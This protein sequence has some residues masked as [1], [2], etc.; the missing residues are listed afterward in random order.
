MLLSTF[1]NK[2]STFL[3]EIFIRYHKSNNNKPICFI[4][5]LIRFSYKITF[6]NSVKSYN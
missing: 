3:N 6:N 5:K 2:F 1:K 4:T